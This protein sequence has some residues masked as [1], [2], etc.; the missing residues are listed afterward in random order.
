MTVPTTDETFTAS[1]YV[2]VRSA[3]DIAAE[4]AS[5]APSR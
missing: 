1:A 4:K 2:P 3:K 5:G